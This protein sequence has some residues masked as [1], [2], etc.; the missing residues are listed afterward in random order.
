MNASVGSEASKCKLQRL[1]PV[2]SV[3]RVGDQADVARF[4]STRPSFVTS[5]ATSYVQL[6]E[7]TVHL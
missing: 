1:S 6:L 7:P 4:S 5:H 2:K 3:V